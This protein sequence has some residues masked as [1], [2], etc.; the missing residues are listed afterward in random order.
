MNEPKPHLK[1]TASEHAV[2]KMLKERHGLKWPHAA[3]IAK[4]V[5]ALRVVDG[6]LEMA[7]DPTIPPIVRRP[8]MRGLESGKSKEEMRAE[9]LAEFQRPLDECGTI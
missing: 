5:V 6:S 4:D 7:L 1:L 2:A 8:K 3:I 9:A